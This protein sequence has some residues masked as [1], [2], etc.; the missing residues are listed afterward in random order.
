[1]GVQEAFCLALAIQIHSLTI[2][3]DQR[4]ALV[5][6]VEKREERLWMHLLL[7]SKNDHARSWRGGINYTV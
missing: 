4:E 2:D 5:P 6:M 7:L 1:M 3:L